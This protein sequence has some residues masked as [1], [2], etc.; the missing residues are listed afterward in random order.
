MTTMTNEYNDIDKGKHNDKDKHN[1]SMGWWTSEG[2][3]QDSAYCPSTN[4]VSTERY[5][6]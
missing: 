1:I 6:H 4:C 2:V 5:S 3:G